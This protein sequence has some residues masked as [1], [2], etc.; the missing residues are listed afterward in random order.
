[1]LRPARAL[2][3]QPSTAADAAAVKEADNALPPLD[4]PSASELKSE[5][6][7]DFL[8]LAN[9]L[10]AGNFKE[11]D[12]LTRDMLIFIAGPGVSTARRP[13]FR[14]HNCMWRPVPISSLSM[15]IQPDIIFSS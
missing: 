6:G 10:Y 2:S 5:T 1:V 3:A 4:P 15:Q 7:A 11:A 14:V 12:Q 8:P 13:T 9:A